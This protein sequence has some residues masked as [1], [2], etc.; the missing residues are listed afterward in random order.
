[1]PATLTPLRLSSVP[2]AKEE[3]HRQA[4]PCKE[5]QL[6]AKDLQMHL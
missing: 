3:Y 5:I 4:S 2:K 6:K 1:M